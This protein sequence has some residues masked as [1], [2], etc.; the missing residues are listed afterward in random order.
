MDH[1]RDAHQERYQSHSLPSSLFLATR[2][3]LGCVAVGKGA[4]TLLGSGTERANAIP[5][6]RGGQGCQQQQSLALRGWI[7]TGNL[8]PGLPST[9]RHRWALGIWWPHRWLLL[10][11][12]VAPG[13]FAASLG[14]HCIPGWEQSPAGL[15][16]L[17]AMGWAVLGPPRGCP[18]TTPSRLSRLL[19]PSPTGASCP[20]Q[21]KGTPEPAQPQGRHLQ[22]GGGA[23][24]VCPAL[25]ALSVL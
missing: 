18:G 23:E 15:H 24:Q 9:V 22:P 4:R 5:W 25:P 2:S 1:A 21:G 13:T 12:L 17:L 3:K 6:P 8:V 10:G 7:C 11:I 20:G 19:S 14:C 16:R